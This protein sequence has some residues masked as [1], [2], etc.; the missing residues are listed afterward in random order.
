MK[1]QLEP[2]DGNVKPQSGRVA[3][4]RAPLA[5]V[6]AWLAAGILADRYLGLPAGLWAVSGSIGL[7]LAAV[8]FRRE[9]LKPLATAGV[10]VAIIALGAIH[11][12]TTCRRVAEDHIVTFTGSSPILATLRGQIIT[13]PMLYRDTTVIGYRRP[14][15]TGFVLRAERILT[16]S[17]WR[18]A[19]GLVRVLIREPADHVAAGQEVELL[20]RIGRFRP[21]ANPGQF[22]RAAAAR[23]KGTLVWMTVPAPDGAIVL[24]GPHGN[25]PE[26]MYWNL[27]AAVRQHLAGLGDGQDA[28]LLG[29]LIIGERD[30][31]LDNLNR[32]MARAGVAHFLSISGLHLGVFLGFIYL[33]C[34]LC[35]LTPRR[36]AIIVLAILAAY[37]LLA[38]P[39]VPLLRSA[40]MAAALCVATIA[41]RR[42]GTLNS[43]S[44]A[45]IVLLVIDPLQ[46]FS[47]GFQLSFAIVYAIVL[48]RRPVR[49]IIFG[50]WL[51]RRGLIVFRTDR[52]LR[53]WMH[54][55][56]GNWLMDGFVIA[57]VAYL[58]ASPLVAYHFGLLAPYAVVLS[59]LLFPLVALVLVPGY[60]S[61]A[62][63]WPLP[64][65]SY[66]IGRF[67]RW[68][69]ELLAQAVNALGVLPGLSFEL[70]P[71]HPGWVVLC[72]AAIALVVF[73]R[74]IPFGKILATGAIMT[75]A[76]W[77][78]LS[79]L[80]QPRPGNAE[81]HVFAVGAGQCCVLRAPS[82]ETL[83]LDAGT[84][85]GYDAHRQVLQPALRAVGLPTPKAAL[86][87]HANTDHFNAVAP[88]IRSGEIRRVYLNDYFG[89]PASTPSAGQSAA[90]RLL[91]LMQAEGVD[92]IRLRAGDSV[93]LDARTR[94]K[95]FWPPRD[96]PDD[97]T[98]NDTSLV[99]RVTCDDESVLLTGD[100]DQHGQEQLSGGAARLAANV[101]MLPH[102]GGWEPSL[103][104]FLDAVDPEV[105]LVSSR[106]D[107]AGAAAGSERAEFYDRVRTRRRY[108]TTAREGWICVHFGRGELR[109]ET[110]R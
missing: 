101:L 18:P 68:A 48:G 30:P 56:L 58:A 31:A 35:L 42:Y 36:S 52:P 99:V 97:L 86:L 108:H 32:T 102:H 70:R 50:R 10:A 75:L 13:S 82:G 12:H 79:Q 60:V 4:R 38:E 83:I 66:T 1:Q 93:Q 6:A 25:W 43:I 14:D 29:A 84:S 74:R 92:V 63:H 95:V 37:V 72:Y 41:R 3:V 96:R 69:A 5:A 85:A 2:A 33:L 54:Y 8:T 16:K 21:P 20:G 45:A 94:M 81:L 87:S 53:R 22:D 49:R 46:L 80:P 40:L 73:S 9:H 44:A 27:R 64:G 103:P 51:R 55:R 107:P 100:L 59:I 67:A 106:R 110:M 17:G 109:V 71:L 24:S 28:R 78:A 39:R 98:V 88:M 23:R 11:F 76:G 57:L 7:V 34:R 26:R 15:R 65:L 89:P 91:A 61:M 77:T 19:S 104:G 105:V 47:P 90:G 62:L